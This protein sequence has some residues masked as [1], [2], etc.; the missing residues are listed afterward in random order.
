MIGKPAGLAAGDHE[1][2]DGLVVAKQRHYQH[3][4]VATDKSAGVLR[5]GQSRITEGVG[6]VQRHSV[7]HG[8]G[9][10]LVRV[11][12]KWKTASVDSVADVVG[13]RESSE[14]ELIARKP[15]QRAR[16]PSQQADGALHDHVEHRLHVGLRAADH[17]QSLPWRLTRRTWSPSS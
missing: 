10:V 16:V 6:A 9:V 17:S 4:S 11:D 7:A 3:A 13:A 14:L 8:L 1:C 15:C 5:S 2:S 12:R